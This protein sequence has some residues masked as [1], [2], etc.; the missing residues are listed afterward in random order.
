MIIQKNVV[1]ITV[2]KDLFWIFGHNF[3]DV[4]KIFILKKY[5]FFHTC[6]FMKATNDNIA[7][8]LFFS[9]NVDSKW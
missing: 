7:F 6:M 4:A 8:L 9:A 5:V 3:Q 1:K 2:N